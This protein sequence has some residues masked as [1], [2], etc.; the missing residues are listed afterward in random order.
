MLIKIIYVKKQYIWN[1]L[2]VF[3]DIAIESLYKIS[4]LKYKYVYKYSDWNFDI[5]CNK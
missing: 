5:N 2:D 3:D 4:R 1:S